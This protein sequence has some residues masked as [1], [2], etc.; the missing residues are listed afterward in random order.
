[1]TILDRISLSRCRRSSNHDSEFE[2]DPGVAMRIPEPIAREL[3]LSKDLSPFDRMVYIFTL[4]Y[5]PGSFSALA[6]KTLLDRRTIAKSCRNLEKAGWAVV[7]R[8]SQAA[9]PIPRITRSAQVIMAKTLEKAYSAAEHKGEFLMKHFLDLKV[10]DHSYVDNGRSSAMKPT[11]D[12]APL[13]LDRWY[14]RAMV[15]F[16]FNGAQHYR[17]TSL[18]K[19]HKEFADAQARDVAKA[20]LCKKAGIKLVIVTPEDLMPGRLEKLI[21]TELARN[22]YVEE[23]VYFATLARICA[24]Y[25]AKADRAG[26]SARFVRR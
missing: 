11:D 6:E 25:C 13:E 16:E 19:S 1:M 14:I 2:G 7:R 23:G 20:D 12:S 26:G 24:A 8:T 17:K 21:P 9:C 10:S 18:H 15:A 3:A 5:Q 4:L 22:R